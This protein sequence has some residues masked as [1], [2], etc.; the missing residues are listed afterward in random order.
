MAQTLP[1]HTA[2]NCIVTLQICSSNQLNLTWGTNL[3]TGMIRIQG[4][5]PLV[6]W[7]RDESG[8]TMKPEI[9]CYCYLPVFLSSFSIHP[10]L[11]AHICPL[12]SILWRCGN[13]VWLLET[14]PKANC[15]GWEARNSFCPIFYYKAHLPSPEC[16]NP[17]FWRW[18]IQ[19]L[20]GNVMED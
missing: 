2:A 3:T 5:S 9:A 10:F 1:R 13:K 20:S 7:D 15:L 11:H 18:N 8:I 12:Y 16:K 14:K 4:G 17:W 6:T 19:S